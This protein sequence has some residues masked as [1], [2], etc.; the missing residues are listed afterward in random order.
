MKGA[1]KVGSI[2]LSNGDADDDN[3]L[4]CG[5]GVQLSDTA[6]DF[7]MDAM[8]VD[9][10][11]LSSFAYT[12]RI[13]DTNN[14]EL[15]SV[16]FHLKEENQETIVD[17]ATP[18]EVNAAPSI[19]EG[20]LP[21]EFSISATKKVHFSQGNLWYG[22]VGDAQTATFNFEANQYDFQ[23]SWSTSHVSHFYWSKTASVTY[24]Q[25]YSE[26]G[27]SGSDVFFTNAETETAKS[28]FTVNG[29][30][31]KY[32]TLSNDEWTYLINKDGD[33][34]IRKGK[35]KYGV[36]V[37]G[38]AN[39]LILAPDDFEGTIAASYD[40]AAW[41][42]AEAAGL[43]CL[44]A[45]GG[46]RDS[47]VKSVGDYGYYW[48]ST[49]FD[50][51][52]AYDVIFNSDN[53]RGDS[54]FRDNGFSVRLVTDASVTPAPTPT[55]TGTAKATIGGSQ[56]DVNWVQ[57]WENGPKFAEYNVGAENSKA[58]DY[59]GY[60]NWGMSDVQTSSNWED[61]KRGESPLSGDDD[62][63]TKLWGSNWR[64]PTQTDLQGLID[65]CDVAWTT[66]NDKD[67]CKFTGKGAYASNSVFLP[68]AGEYNAGDVYGQ[69]GYGK[70]WSSTPGGDDYAYNLYFNSGSQNVD[71]DARYNG[72]SVRAVLA[73]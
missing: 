33:E 57:L 59:G 22:K 44:P 15:K 12:L 64:M 66:V 32:R 6:T 23:N 26:F 17:F 39:C 65:N 14:K 71:N 16:S 40:A 7:Y 4:S 19:P 28:D 63:A 43:V 34:N 18:I 58:E 46:L 51:F 73:E 45:A 61:Y 27:T 30:T 8:Y 47:D 35:H 37:C 48:S 9:P 67:G 54:H 49:A 10:H 53:V 21:G 42:T 69:G 25:S 24:A 13:Y 50:E 56:V 29:V 3:T 20:A 2:A 41:T 1:A 70:Y 68:A 31:G 60:Y 38:K 36:T 5:D 52:F 55:T 11:K 62:T 72:Y